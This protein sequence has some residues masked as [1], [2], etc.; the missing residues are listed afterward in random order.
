VG[1]SGGVVPRSQVRLGGDSFGEWVPSEVT[2]RSE[3]GDSSGE[4]E[5]SSEGGD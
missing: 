4:V 3:G 1:K 5:I 2:L